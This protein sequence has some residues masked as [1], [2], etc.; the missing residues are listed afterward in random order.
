V[1]AAA[2]QVYVLA[3]HQTPSWARFVGDLFEGLG[4]PRPTR[5]FPRW[6]ALSAAALGE[7]WARLSRRPPLLTRYRVDLVSRDCVFRSRKAHRELGWRPEVPPD[8]ALDETVAWLRGY[9]G[10]TGF[11][12]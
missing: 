1:P 3:D 4:L 9:L 6:A 5:S 12:G 10:E 8:R 11:E 7:A 2:G